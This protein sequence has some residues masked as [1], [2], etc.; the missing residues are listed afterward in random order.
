MYIESPQRR[1]ETAT[2]IGSG[3]LAEGLTLVRASTLKMIRLQ[4]AMERRDRH[5]ALEAVDDLIALDRHLQQYLEGVLA[6][7]DQQLF[8]Q[9][10]DAE[11]AALNREKLTLTAEILRR[12]AP[13]PEPTNS[14]ETDW[15]GPRDLMVETEEPRSNR[16]WLAVVPLVASGLAAA[17]YCISLS[18]S[19]AWFAAVAG[20]LK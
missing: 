15:I 13:S 6:P 5:V 11:R 3:E 10:L 18:E 20:V 16:W 17:A 8:R 2:L 14:L 19:A 4:L 9:A 1:P 7:A 12:P